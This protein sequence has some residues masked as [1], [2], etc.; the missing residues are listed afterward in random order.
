[1]VVD[2]KRALILARKYA[3]IIYQGWKSILDCIVPVQF[4]D[5]NDVK[6]RLFR[7]AEKPT[8]YYGVREDRYYYYLFYMIYHAFDWSSSRVWLIR[9]LDS[10]RHDTESV[11]FRVHKSKLNGPIDVCT[12]FH[13]EFIFEINTDR[14]VVIE[15][16]GHGIKPYTKMKPTRNYL[17]YQHYEFFDLNTLD[18]KE[19]NSWKRE[20]NGAKMPDE[21]Y[22]R[23]FPRRGHK[24]GDIWRQPNRVFEIAKRQRRF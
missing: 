13:H 16:E 10:H 9:V 17:V 1:M 3:P 14:R 18:R 23:A 24:K 15:P 8:L 6:S 5:A 22:D 21:H 20:F 7:E 11:L 12:I 2:S 19:W 4:G